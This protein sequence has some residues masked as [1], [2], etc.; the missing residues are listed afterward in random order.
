MLSGYGK[1]VKSINILM[2]TFATFIQHPPQVHRFHIPL[3]EA[4]VVGVEIYDQYVEIFQNPRPGDFTNDSLGMS[5]KRPNETRLGTAIHGRMYYRSA[6]IVTQTDWYVWD[7]EMAVHEDV[8][9]RLKLRPHEYSKAATLYVGY[10]PW[11]RALGVDE[12]EWTN[13]KLYSND[14]LV[15]MMSAH[16]AIK[17][18]SRVV[19]M[20]NL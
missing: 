2:E 8:L 11:S 5:R 17:G 10:F 12:S 3:L 9:S 4:T 16:P 14:G 18:F 20:E 19:H 15:D 13:G 6:A 1:F 7:R